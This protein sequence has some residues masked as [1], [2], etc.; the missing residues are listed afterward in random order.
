MTI[1]RALACAACFGS[2]LLIGSIASAQTG[3]SA[4]ADPVFTPAKARELFA[5]LDLSGD[6]FKPVRDA[7][8]ANDLPAAEHALAD[9]FRQRTSV[10]WKFDPHKKDP[11]LRFNQKAADNGVDGRFQLG[12]VLISH[13]FPSGRIDWF[14]NPT[15]NGKVP[16][17]PEWQWGL[18]RMPFWNDMATAYRATGDERYPRA[19]VRQLRSFCAQCPPPAQMNNG[20]GSAWRTIEAGI[21][22]STSWPTAYFGFLLSPSVSDRDLLLCV[23]ECRAHALYLTKCNT[24]GN[25]L[26]MEMNGLYTVGAVFPEFREAAA[27]RN[28]AAGRMYALEKSQFLPDGAQEELTTGYHNVSVDNITA[29]MNVA[30]LTG[31]SQELPAGFIDPMEK[32]YDFDMYMSGPNGQ[33]PQFNDSWPANVGGLL[34]HALQFFPGRQDYLWFATKGAQ[35][36]QPAQTSHAFD[37]AGYYV[38]RSSWAGDANYLVFRAGPLG[39]RHSHQDKLNL[40]FWPYGREVLYNSGGAT[41]DNSAWRRY[42]ID[43]FSKNTVLVDGL[44]QHRNGSDRQTTISH[45]PIDARWEST[46]DHD[47]AAGTYDGPYG[48]KNLHPAVHSRRVLF[49]KPDLAVVADTLTPT[50]GAAHTYQA[51]WNLLTVHTRIVDGTREVITTDGNVPN[52]DLVPLNSAQ[53]DV[54]SA[55]AQTKPELLGWDCIH[56]GSPPRPATTVLQT[57]HGTGVQTFLT[58]LVPLR[59]GAPD[60]VKTVTSTGPGITQIIFSDGRRLDVTADPNPAAGIEATETLPDGTPGRHIRAGFPHP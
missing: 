2:I 28:D 49:L 36:Q 11:T 8:A 17:N 56:D 32:A 6:Q 39:A 1:L 44:P 51:R 3:A 18:C 7:L 59:P 33:M 46:P 29:L 26:T 10:P 42:S 13:L 15:A 40:I 22:M 12:G 54:R 57:R 30:Q 34:K 23:Y 50:D 60:P 9:Y 24:S 21:R 16:F 4:A 52:L 41:Y 35:G 43:T 31:H 25:W 55:S 58:L 47:F 48:P 14:Y 38:M 27:W 45:A 20:V 19:W 5:A 37:W 53:L